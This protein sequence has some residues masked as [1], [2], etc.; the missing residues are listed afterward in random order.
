M[1]LHEKIDRITTNKDLANFIEALRSDLL[2]NPNDWENPNLE[3]FLEAM[4]AW[5]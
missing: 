3:R 2:A 1:E 4:A 5:I